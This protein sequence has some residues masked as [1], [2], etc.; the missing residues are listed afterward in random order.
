MHAGVHRGQ[1]GHSAVAVELG[2]IRVAG[3]FF[4]I[5][6]QAISLTSCFVT[7]RRRRRRSRQFPLSLQNERRVWPLLRGG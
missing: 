3:E 1:H 7:V 5:S 2:V 4:F 6:V